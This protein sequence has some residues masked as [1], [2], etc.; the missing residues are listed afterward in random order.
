[1]SASYH[2]EAPGLIIAFERHDDLAA[3]LAAADLAVGDEVTARA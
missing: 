3:A 2:P 1:M